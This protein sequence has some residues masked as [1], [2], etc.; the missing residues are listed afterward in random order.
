MAP[1]KAAAAKTGALEGFVAVDA[2]PVATRASWATRALDEFL[3]GKDA[4]IACKY[5]QEKAAVSKQAALNKA[6]KSEAFAGKVKI[7]RRGDTIYIE[8]L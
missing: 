4:I 1:R 5:D 6:A 3:A 2:I 8:R 7:H